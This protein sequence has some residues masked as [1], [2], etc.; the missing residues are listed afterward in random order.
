MHS[1]VIVHIYGP[2]RQARAQ[3]REPASAERTSNT[4]I[5]LPDNF[6]CG[7]I[8][9]YF[10]FEVDIIAFLDVFR[11]QIRAQLQ[12][13]RR[14]DCAT[15]QPQPQPPPPV[16]RRVCM[17]AGSEHASLAASAANRRQPAEPSE[18]ASERARVCV[19]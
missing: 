9:M 19:L 13:Q 16:D 5:M 1:H 7:R 18:R 14:H 12:Q 10:A 15:P 17:C 8:C 4:Y 2:G 11:I 3:A 6:V